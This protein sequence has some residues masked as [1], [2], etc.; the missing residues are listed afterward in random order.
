LH[1]ETIIEN[2]C[3]ATAVTADHMNTIRTRLDTRLMKVEQ[4]L[5]SLLEHCRRGTVNDETAAAMRKQDFER[6][7]LHDV[8][9]LVNYVE[10]RIE[11]LPSESLW[12][13]YVLPTVPAAPPNRKARYAGPIE[14]PIA[15]STRLSTAESGNANQKREREDTTII[16]ETPPPSSFPRASLVIPREMTD[17]Y[18]DAS[19]TLFPL[20]AAAEAAALAAEITRVARI[21]VLEQRQKQ[22]QGANFLGATGSSGSASS[23]SSRTTSFLNLAE[24]DAPAMDDSLTPEYPVP[25]PPPRTLGVVIDEG[26]TV[27]PLSLPPLLSDDGY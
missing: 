17:R 3:D 2:L 23:T 4:A 18:K 24:K 8:R 13:P 14:D 26:D 11:P 9:G 19:V 27:M 16:P 1:N 12:Q 10:F 7:E 20:T 5:N 25:D 6:R 21:E 15:R 22:L